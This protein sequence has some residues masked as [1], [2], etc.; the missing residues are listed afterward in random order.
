MFLFEVEDEAAE[1]AEEASFVDQVTEGLLSVGQIHWATFFSKLCTGLIGVLVMLLLVKWADMAIG[2][3]MRGNKRISLLGNFIRKLVRVLCYCIIAIW[4]TGHLGL[5]M[6]PLIAGVGVTGVVLGLALQET[7]GNFFSGLMI[8]V[9]QPFN[10]GD[11][12]E[13]GAFSGTVTDMDMNRVELLTP[14]NKRITMSNKLVWGNPVVNYSAMDKRRVD[15]TASVA[16]G[17]DLDKAKKVLGDLLKTYPEVLPTPEPTIEVGSLDDSS[18]DF[19]VRPWVKPADYWP[20]LWRFQKDWYDTL[21]KAGIQVPYNQLD[22]HI[23]QDKG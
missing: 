20:V 1:I 11:Y 5:D 16:Y 6:K 22:V 21:T 9:N 3:T 12:I 14:D 13:S 19:L 18:I 7:I 15:M 2:R 8:I 10:I 4:F 23:I 17:S